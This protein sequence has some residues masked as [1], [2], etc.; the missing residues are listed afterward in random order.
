MLRNCECG[1]HLKHSKTGRCRSCN[2]RFNGSHH[3]GTVNPIS[4]WT[5]EDLEKLQEIY[6]HTFKVKQLRSELDRVHHRS[7]VWSMS[8]DLG[9]TKV[10]M[11]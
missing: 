9:Y 3:K 4:P 2:A 8:R 5:K 1:A 7:Q 11:M 10:R 6:L